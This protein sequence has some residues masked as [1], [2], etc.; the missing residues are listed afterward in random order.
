[1]RNRL[2]YTADKNRLEIQLYSKT[3]NDYFTLVV[4][5]AAKRIKSN[6]AGYCCF[7]H[8]DDINKDITYYD[9]DEYELIEL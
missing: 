1:M 3:K 8:S 9:H 6:K 4:Y 5:Y 2:L 7:T